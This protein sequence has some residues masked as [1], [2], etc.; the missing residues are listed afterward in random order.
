MMS[1]KSHGAEH[2]QEAGEQPLMRRDRLEP[3]YC[4]LE[5]HAEEAGLR[6][7]NIPAVSHPQQPASGLRVN[8]EH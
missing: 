5:G 4:G 8:L 7:G 3:E 1:M 6:R 2:V